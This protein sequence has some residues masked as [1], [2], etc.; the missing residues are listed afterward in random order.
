MACIQ[1]LG[2]ECLGQFCLLY[3]PLFNEYSELI[4]DF[5]K[6]GHSEI[7]VIAVKILFDLVMF[8]GKDEDF[9]VSFCQNIDLSS[10]V[11][12]FKCAL[13][14]DSNEELQTI[15]V[16]G[17]AK[18]LLCKI[19]QDQSILEGLMLLYFHPS[20]VNRPRMR[21]CL[22]YFFPA[23]SFSS[24]SNQLLLIPLVIPVI[25]SVCSFL[26]ETPKDQADI[27]VKPL[28]AADQILYWLDYC[29]LNEST[30]NISQ[31]SLMDI[32]NEND[33]SVSNEHST[34]ITEKCSLNVHG[35]VAVEL[36]KNCFCNKNENS[37][38]FIQLL[39]RLKIDCNCSGKTIKKIDFLATSLLKTS[40]DK[41]ICNNLRKF[42]ASFI[43]FDDRT[44][45]L[46]EEEIEELKNLIKSK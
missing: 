5:F 29:H 43:E 1:E 27:I 26:Q 38:F 41:V 45:G 34:N 9:S 20:S 46:N 33:P 16:E 36:L 2:L 4:T 28:Q 10:I 8:Y 25:Q 12:C 11:N 3:R 37:K 44:V 6:L 7:K 23:F 24:H 15:A 22:C 42:V 30:R 32:S 17:C 21:Q 35:L 40:S 19:I 14:D 31:E 18:L 39:S 13:C